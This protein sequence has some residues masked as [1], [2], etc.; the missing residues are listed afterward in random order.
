MEGREL[1][2][3]KVD[4]ANM[5]YKI[6]NNNLVGV[7]ESICEEMIMEK[8]IFTPIEKA[9]IGDHPQICVLCNIIEIRLLLNYLQCMVVEETLYHAIIVGRNQCSERSQ[10]LLLHIR[11][12]SGI[13]KS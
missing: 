12:K 4:L 7:L 5:G 11:G 9:Q 3:I 8:G 10:Q 13:G 2:E 6:D 1:S